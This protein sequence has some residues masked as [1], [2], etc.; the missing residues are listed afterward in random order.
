MEGGVRSTIPLFILSLFLSQFQCIPNRYHGQDLT[1]PWRYRDF[2]FV[3]LTSAWP[4]K[5][6]WRYSLPRTSCL[7]SRPW[8]RRLGMKDRRSNPRSLSGSQ[9]HQTRR[10]TFSFSVSKKIARF[11]ENCIQWCLFGCFFVLFFFYKLSFKFI[12]QTF[13]AIH[14]F[15]IVFTDSMCIY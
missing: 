10:Q 8:R 2:R 3:R 12:N 4:G 13:F 6:F 11:A 9:G 15:N 14:W 7:S 1:K 5:G